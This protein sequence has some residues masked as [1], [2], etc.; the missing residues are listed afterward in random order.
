MPIMEP[1][2]WVSIFAAAW[3]MGRDCIIATKSVDVGS[4]NKI[5]FQD[6]HVRASKTT[7]GTSINESTTWKLIGLLAVD[8][9]DDRGTNRACVLNAIDGHKLDRI[10]LGA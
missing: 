7:V 5:S 10:G 4:G 1:P 6:V 3:T 9:V 8:I 2:P